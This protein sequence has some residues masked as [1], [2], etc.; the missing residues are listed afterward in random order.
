M[1]QPNKFLSI[2]LQKSRNRNPPNVAKV[3]IVAKFANFDDV[4]KG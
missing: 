2:K 1:N 3:A 4:L